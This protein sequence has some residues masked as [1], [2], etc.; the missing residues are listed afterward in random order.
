MNYRGSRAS[1]DQFL[2]RRG[3]EAPALAKQNFWQAAVHNM[4]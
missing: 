4:Q 1:G 2:K 3:R